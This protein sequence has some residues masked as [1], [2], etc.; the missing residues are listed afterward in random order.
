MKTLRATR[1]GAI[2]LLFCAQITSAMAVTFLHDNFISFA[3]HSYDGQDIVVTNC[4]LT[5]DGTHTFNSVQL[6]NG[7]VLTHSAFPYG[8]QQFSVSVSDESQTF[9]AITPAVLS[10]TNVDADSILVFDSSANILYT[11]GVDYHV[12][13]SNQFTELTLTA[14]SAIAEGASVLVEYDWAQDFQGVNLTINNSLQV[15]AGAAINISG[16]GYAGGIGFLNGA[17]TSHATNYPFV[18]TAGG[19]GAYGGSGGMSSTSARGGGAYGS[20]TNPATLGSGGG[21]GSAGG[22][23]GGGVVALVVG[24]NLQVDG[25][26]FADGLKGTN[27]HCGGGSGGSLWISAQSFSGAGAISA[28]GGSADLPDGGGGGGGRIAIYSGTN[29]FTGTISAFGGN[30]A[31]VGG[32]GTIYLQSIANP[33]GR[34]FI[35]NGGK[36]GT[37][38]SFSAAISDLT[39]SKGAIAQPQSSVLFVTNLFVGSNSWLVPFDG[40]ALVLSVNGNATLE[41]NSAINANFRSTSGLGAGSG[42]CGAGSGGSYGGYGG[43]SVCGTPGGAVMA[44]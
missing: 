19:G 7:S 15:G 37:N 20:T 21:S 33:A 4:T 24:G 38:T 25:Q 29:N 17:G 32:A 3:D 41:S 8:P 5:V 28:N 42:I 36:R 30:G 10:N 27:A 2:A 9:S 16:K 14:N 18:F 23:G 13:L 26:I 1:L 44:R 11:E 40:T 31:T 12:T 35:V 6:L 39:I 34:L 22:G 43:N